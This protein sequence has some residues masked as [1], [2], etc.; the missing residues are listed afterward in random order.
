ML[1]GQ[2]LSSP[3]ARALLLLL[4]LCFAAALPGAQ[5]RK[6][7]KDSVELAVQGCLK[8]R[9]LAVVEP[10]ERHGPT[11]GPDVTGRSFRLSGKKP[12]IDEVKKHDGDL[13]EVVGLV[14]TADLASYQPGMRVGRTRVVI[15]APGTMDP[16]RPPSPGPGLPVMDASSVRF[17]SE[18]CPIR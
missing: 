2:K 12:V 9:V 4:L 1:P 10:E 3:H 13:V 8:G 17:L 7:P 11:R 18:G 15:G 5:E 16:N 6:V 14:R